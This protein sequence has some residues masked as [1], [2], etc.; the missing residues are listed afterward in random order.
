MH[1]LVSR[2]SAEKHPV[3]FLLSRFLRM[4]KLCRLLHIQRRGYLLKFHPSSLAMS[5]WVDPDY[6]RS[7]S[8]VI[9]NLLREGDSYVDVGANIG[10]LTIEA[11]LA[12]G[13]TGTITAFEAH[14]RIAEY[15]R[16]N[17]E[18]N[19][20][21]R[22]R[23]AQLAVGDDFR[24]IT[25][26]NVDSDDQ[27]RVLPDGRGITVPMVRLDAF[28]AGEAITLLKVDVEGWEKFVFLGAG[29][30]LENVSF[31]Y[32]E[33]WD[34]HFLGAGYSF[35]DIHDILSSRGF[36]IASVE[37]GELLPIQRDSTFPRCVNLFAFKDMEKFVIRMG[38]R[39]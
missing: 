32:F 16:E 30:V 36:T 18:L 29:R 4:T 15:L 39:A 12:V 5:L 9:R 27:N 31:V 23:A 33:C 3:R 25:F 22:V 14:P 17:V 13:D 28:F 35:V 21:T 26:S 8:T 6:S 19:N 20:L 2:L 1:F 7:D 24:W 10:H 38:L 34:E 11:A 37:D